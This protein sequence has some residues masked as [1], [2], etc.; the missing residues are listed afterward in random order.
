MAA[1]VSTDR[2]A[3][4]RRECHA[5][6]FISPQHCTSTIQSHPLEL[7]GRRP[8]FTLRSLSSSTHRDVDN[9]DVVCADDLKICRKSN[10]GFAPRM[11]DIEHN[12]PERPCRLLL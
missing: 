4:R 6:A 2:V 11:N 3:G 5:A 1:T 7:L 10:G 9:T 12:S 8:V